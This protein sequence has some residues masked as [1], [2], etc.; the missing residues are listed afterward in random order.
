MEPHKELESGISKLAPP[1]DKGYKAYFRKAREFAELYY[2]DELKRIGSTKFSDV[3][4]EF[5]FNE[6]V[7]VVHAT[8]F[9]AKAVGKFMPKLMVAY[10]PW[11]QL[12]DDL[13]GSTPFKFFERV[14]P[15]CNNPQKAKAI[16][17]MAGIMLAGVQKNGW[18]KFKQDTL[19]SPDLLSTLPYIGKVTCF[20]LGR[21][22]GL[23][24]CVKPDLHLIRLAEH[25]KFKDCTE[26]CK[27][28]GKGTALPLGIVD[29]IIWYAAS[30]FG[31][32]GIKK[33]GQR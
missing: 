13:K 32:L 12:G 11:P 16:Q 20:H 19:S 15:V 2:N 33:D 27:K 1:L 30:T 5:F 25:F 6:Y 26:M 9:S 29:L 24:D 22:I 31:T 3:T 14:Q 8:G 28:M 21:N 7:W 23:L 10:G 17:K 4:P 18:D